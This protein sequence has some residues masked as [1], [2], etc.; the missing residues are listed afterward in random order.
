MKEGEDFEEPIMIIF[1]PIIYAV[2]ANVA[3]TAGPIYDVTFYRE[4][5]R[6]KLLK[7][8]YVFSLILMGLPGLW[9][10]VAWLMTVVTG[11]KL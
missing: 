2:L 3:Y 4:G 10:V 1:G 9:A 6:K 8:G 7:A 11:Q 5:P